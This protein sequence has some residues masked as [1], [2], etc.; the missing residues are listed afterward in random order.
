MALAASIDCTADQVKIHVKKMSTEY[1]E[2]ETI[3]IKDGGTA[4]W[5]SPAFVG[6]ELYEADVCLT[7]TTNL[8]YTMTLMD[9][10][11]SLPFFMV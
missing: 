4:L 7:R 6:G 3:V 9:E 11:F 8:Q 1:P 5:T 2:E 10:L